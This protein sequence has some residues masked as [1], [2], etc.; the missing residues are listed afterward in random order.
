MSPF[1]LVGCWLQ[2]VRSSQAELNFEGTSFSDADAG[3]TGRKMNEITPQ[4]LGAT[5]LDEP[6]VPFGLVIPRRRRC[7]NLIEKLKI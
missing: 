1:F 3:S 6:L 2:N 4:G 5:G 7:R